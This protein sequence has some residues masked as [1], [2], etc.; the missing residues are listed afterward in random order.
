[1]RKDIDRV[2]AHQRRQAHRRAYIV[3]KDQE[4]G[5]V[6]DEPT[7]QRQPVQHRSHRMLAHAKVQVDAVERAAVDIAAS[8]DQRVRRGR[9]VG[10]SAHQGGQPGRKGIDHLARSASRRQRLA[11]VRERRQVGVP[12]IGQFAHNPLL[13]FRGQIGIRGSIGFETRVPLRFVGLTRRDG[14]AHVRQGLVGD[15]EAGRRRPT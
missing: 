10:R 1:M 7:V 6:G 11:G 8:R 15:Q 3:G 9:Q 5:A 4:C 14:C 2:R 12:P 13:E